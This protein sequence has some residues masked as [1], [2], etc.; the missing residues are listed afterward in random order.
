M[1]IIPMCTSAHRSMKN[2]G[3]TTMETFPVSPPLKR[4]PLKRPTLLAALVAAAFAATGCSLAPKYQVPDAQV[5][6][7]YKETATD[8]TQT[9]IKVPTDGTWKTAEPSEAI[10]RG[11]WWTIFND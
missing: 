8:F 3:H 7:A 4:A 9:A 1:A 5:A 10:A 6:P 11:Q 2:K